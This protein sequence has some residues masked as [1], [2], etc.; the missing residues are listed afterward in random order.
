VHRR[1]ALRVLGAGA[2]IALALVA[3]GQPIG[4]APRIALLLAGTRERY[5]GFNGIPLFRNRLRELC[6][7]DGKSILIREWYADDDALRLIALA[8]EI[9]NSEVDIIVTP[10][11]AA[12]IAAR[13]ATSTIPI[14]MVHAGDP[15]GAGLVA[16]LA[17]PGGNVTGSTNMLLGGKQVEL[18][19]ELVPRFRRLGVLVNPTN[20]GSRPVLANITDTARGLGIE[21]VVAEVKNSEDLSRALVMLANGRLDGLTVMVEKVIADNEAQVLQFAAST[22]LPTCYDTADTVRGGGLISYGPVL[23]EQYAFAAVYVDKI[24]KGTKPWDLPVQQ[25]TKF[26]LAIN[27]KTAKALGLTIPQSLL[28][29][30]DEIIK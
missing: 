9:A 15:V 22:R 23:D 27:L 10:T 18:L 14:V 21:L 26:E 8:R 4:K 12:S 7:I 11:I 13:Q 19:R 28:L 24:L 29:R 25:P 3:R 17:R 5:A 16:S 2:L 20:A 1:A 30:A 6:Y